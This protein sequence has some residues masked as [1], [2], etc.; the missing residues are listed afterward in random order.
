MKH[1]QRLALAVLAFVCLLTGCAAKPRQQDRTVY[2]MDTVM[3]LRI[4]SPEKDRTLDALETLLKE[5][6][7]DL[8]ATDPDS[9]LSKLNVTGAAS[10]KDLAELVR[11]AAAGRQSVAGLP[12][13]GLPLE[14]LSGAGARGPGGPPQPD[15]HGQG[16]RL[17]G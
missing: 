3:S 10:E 1:L 4:Y 7:R 17:R 2:T 15:R 16:F 6:D 9:R 5:L 8:S 14:A 13:L 12:P 11:R